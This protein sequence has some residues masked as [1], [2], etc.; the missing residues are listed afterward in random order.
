MRVIGGR[1][2]LISVAVAELSPASL[3]YNCAS[4]ES[5]M[6]DETRGDSQLPEL[7]AASREFRARKVAGEVALREQP[8]EFAKVAAWHKSTLAAARPRRGA[9]V[10]FRHF[11]CRPPLAERGVRSSSAP[12]VC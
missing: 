9:A 8:D 4:R 12:V 10:S 7:A 3:P 6:R 2:E 11:A 1:A 5:G